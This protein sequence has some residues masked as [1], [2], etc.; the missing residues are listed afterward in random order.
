MRQILANHFKNILG[1]KTKRRLVVLS[2]DDYGNVRLDSKD[3]REKMNIAGLKVLN[4]FD[5]YDTLETK[6]DL[7]MLYEALSSV[8]DKNGNAAVFTPFSIPCNIDFERMG[9]E[10]YSTYHY[11]LLPTTFSKLSQKNPKAYEGTWELWNEGIK[12]KLMAPQFH[13]RE[14]FNLKVFTEKLNNKDAEL[15]TALKNR[16]N[17]S[18]SK[19]GYKTINYTAAFEFWEFSENLKLQE[20]IEDGL[21]N[22]KTVFGYKSTHFNPPGGREHHSLH[23]K[24]S[25]LGVKSI[26]NS[27]IKKENQGLGKYET[28]IC[29]NG[30]F[31]SN[32]MLQLVRNVVFEPNSDSSLDSVAMAMSQIDIAFKYNSP[33]NISSHRVN[34]CGHVDQNNR[35][36][37]IDS[38]KK[39]LKNIVSKYP[40]VEFVSIEE[41]VSIMLKDKGKYNEN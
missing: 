4:R 17:T 33:V 9:Q 20:I 16:S 26:D 29:L 22:F 18:I 3:A 13:G 32:G 35:K 25:S 41:L 19:T 7:E 37:G 14:H 38:L 30:S 2:I 11:E 39:L 6:E 1:W 36:E 15:L 21:N 34:F 12:K 24:L 40:D 5:A 31:N 10:N 23:T 8:K 27:F 28:K